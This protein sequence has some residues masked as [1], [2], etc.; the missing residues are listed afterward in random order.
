MTS[1]KELELKRSRRTTPKLAKR[2]PQS[3]DDFEAVVH[4]LE[5]DEDKVHFEE[6]LGKI[7][8]AKPLAE[9]RK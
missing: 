3:K 4:R 5:C 8:K 2:R 9:L 1:A 6:K 7:A